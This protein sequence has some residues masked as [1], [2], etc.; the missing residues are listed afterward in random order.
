MQH[1][2]ITNR[3]ILSDANGEYINTD[4]G[5]AAGENLRFGIFD[6]DVYQQTH[7]SRQAIQLFPDASAIPRTASVQTNNVIPY[8]VKNIET[9]AKEL[10]GSERLF[11][12]LYKAMSGAEGGDLLFFVH[13]FHTDLK[14]SLQSVIDLEKRYINKGSPIKHIIFF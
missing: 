8:D 14:G 1:Y 2:L 11:F 6:S 10:F 12:E 7:D 4:G 3:V 5:E 13:G 9:P